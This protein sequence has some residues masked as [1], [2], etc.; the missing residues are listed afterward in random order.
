MK[1]GSYR[2]LIEDHVVTTVN[3]LVPGL[4]LSPSLSLLSADALSSPLEQLDRP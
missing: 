2:R 1:A 3:S 4:F